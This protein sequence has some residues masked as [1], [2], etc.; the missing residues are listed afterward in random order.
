MRTGYAPHD[1]LR[2]DV[3]AETV[4]DAHAALEIM[5]ADRSSI[6]AGTLT[7]AE[8]GLL[9][10]CM[11]QM[12]RNAGITSDPAT[13]HLAPPTIKDLYEVLES[14]QCGP[15]PTGLASRLRRYV[16]G[17]LSGLFSGQSSVKMDSPVVVFYV[18]QDVEVRAIIYFLI[19]RHVWNVSFGSSI[20]Y[21][22][23]PNQVTSS[24]GTAHHTAPPPRR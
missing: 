9:D 16:D 15:D 21:F 22:E 7:A 17:S 4:Q 3:L 23:L 18:P 2:T 12:F 14:G 8:K 24:C 10:R 20:P 1:D 13:H 5:L 11:Y 19:A 6:G